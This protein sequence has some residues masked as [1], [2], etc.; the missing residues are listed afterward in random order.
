MLAVRLG[1][2]EVD[3]WSMDRSF[4][5]VD[6]HIDLLQ[7]IPATPPRSPWFPWLSAGKAQVSEMRDQQGREKVSRGRGGSTNIQKILPSVAPV[8]G[9]RGSVVGVAYDP[10]T[11]N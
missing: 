7:F 9:G 6:P 1:R 11:L 5:A 2:N 8:T 10:L 4:T 3:G